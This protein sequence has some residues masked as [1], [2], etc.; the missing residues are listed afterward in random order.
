MV[1]R[2]A[3]PDDLNAIARIQAASPTASQWEPQDYL[4]F[5][6]LVA[7][8]PENGRLA[9]FLVSRATGAGRT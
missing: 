2:A 7:E 3:T 4:G 8:L 6:C 1:L 9:G 5:D